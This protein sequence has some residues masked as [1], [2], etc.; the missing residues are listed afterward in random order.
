M[1]LA[2]LEPIVDLYADLLVS[3]SDFRIVQRLL[4]SPLLNSNGVKVVFLRL[5]TIL[6]SIV[7][8][9]DVVGGIRRVLNHLLVSRILL[10]S[11]HLVCIGD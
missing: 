10:K 5:S 8:V 3:Q 4:L 9:D 7:S 6:F 2:L 1:L 11:R